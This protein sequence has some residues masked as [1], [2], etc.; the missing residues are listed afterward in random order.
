MSTDAGSNKD[1]KLRS[2]KVL[3]LCIGVDKGGPLRMGLARPICQQAHPKQQDMASVYTIY[4]IQQ[5][6]SKHTQGSDAKPFQ[7]Q[8]MEVRRAVLL[9]SKFCLVAKTCKFKLLHQATLSRTCTPSHVHTHIQTLILCSASH[10]HITS[11]AHMI[12]TLQ[13][14]PDYY[15][16]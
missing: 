9:C 3:N 13:L 7:C 8:C 4:I 15:G 14:H 16:S 1:S 5:S 11:C 12:L 10:N 6:N 2:T